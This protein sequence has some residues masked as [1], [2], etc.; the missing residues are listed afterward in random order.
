[1]ACD[2]W[3]GIWSQLYL[4]NARLYPQGSSVFLQSLD[5]RFGSCSVVSLHT[6]ATASWESASHAIELHPV[7]GTPSGPP[8]SASPAGPSPLLLALVLPRCPQ[9]LHVDLVPPC[10]LQTPAPVTFASHH[11]LVRVAVAERMFPEPKGGALGE[12]HIA[13]R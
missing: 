2:L 9:T 6:L 12:V 8:A 4:H 1:M 13:E 3:L 5:R 7:P 11:G 10:W